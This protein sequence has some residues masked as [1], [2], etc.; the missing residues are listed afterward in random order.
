MEH[1]VFPEHLLGDLARITGAGR[2]AAQLQPDGTKVPAARCQAVVEE[3]HG[4][5]QTLQADVR[6]GSVWGGG[7]GDGLVFSRGGV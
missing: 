5:M 1:A 6:W 7:G 2:R 4:M 3:L